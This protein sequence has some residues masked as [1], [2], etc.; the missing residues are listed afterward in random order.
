MQPDLLK[1]IGGRAAWTGADLAS[2]PSW[3]FRLEAPA[4]A[5]IDAALAG[6]R[7]RGLPLPR[8]RAEDFPLPTVRPLL[9]TV[10]KELEDGRGLVRISGLP[11]ER[12]S[13]DDMKAVFWGIC[14]HLGT[15]LPHR[16]GRDRAG[17]HGRRALRPR[18]FPLHRSTALPHGQM[19]RA[20]PALR[21]KRHRGRGKP[22]RLHRGHP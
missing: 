6:I 14:A 9:E 2:D 7:A 15:P 8:I 19:R 1:P 18:P 22:H 21:L 12:Y 4:I 11:A 13:A 16:R 5:E 17:C 20:C 10:S 3:V